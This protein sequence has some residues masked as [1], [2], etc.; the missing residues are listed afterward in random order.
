M[1]FYASMRRRIASI[2]PSSLS[3][4]GSAEVGVF[5]PEGLLAF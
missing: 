1:T 2:S 4:E 3:D 5:L